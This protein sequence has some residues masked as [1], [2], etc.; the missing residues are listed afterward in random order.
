MELEEYENFYECPTSEK[1]RELCN[2]LLTDLNTDPEPIA[3]EKIEIVA[4]RQWNTYELA[5]RGTRL[6]IEKWLVDHWTDQNDFFEFA[7][8]VTLNM[9]LRRDLYVRALKAYTG[10]C[11]SEFE[12]YLSH[13]TESHYLDPYAEV[14]KKP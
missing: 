2:I 8:V 7:M 3:C 10:D 5:E 11:R 4:D 12:G 13:Q 6:R 9:R 1:M 14:G